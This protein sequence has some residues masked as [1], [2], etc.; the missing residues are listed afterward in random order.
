MSG[1]NLPPGCSVSDIPGNRREDLA[2]EAFWAEWEKRAEAAGLDPD[3]P[4][5]VVP[6]AEPDPIARAL[7]IARDIGYERGYEEGQADAGL[8][9]H[10]AEGRDAHAEEER[11]TL[12]A[13]LTLAALQYG[14]PSGQ[15]AQLERLG[16]PNA[17]RLI[18]DARAR[19]EEPDHGPTQAEF[20]QAI[21][22]HDRRRREDS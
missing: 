4:P 6:L 14:D 16:V 21:R 5:L 17:A 3:R 12:I 19:A 11:C 10:V 22:D 13:S 9:Q 1:F 15:I 20:E 18:A 8:A 7:E 2:D